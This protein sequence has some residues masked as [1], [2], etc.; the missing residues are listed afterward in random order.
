MKE[1]VVRLTSQ[2]IDERIVDTAA[3]VFAVHGYAKTS[4][5]QIADASGYSK[6]GL[7]HRFTSKQGIYDAVVAQTRSAAETTVA[8]AETLSPHAVLELVAQRLLA[9]PG[10]AAML[11]E[12]LRPAADD[13]ARAGL[14][15]ATHRLVDLLEAG[16]D[17]EQRLRGYLALKLV[18]DAAVLQRSDVD[19][20]L[21]VAATRLQPLVVELAAGV[22]GLHEQE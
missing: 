9:Q 5:Q 3:F 15:A 10:I 11:L 19:D 12:S 21:K 6:T 2:E 18:V 17:P 1:D 16:A 20:H 22:L 4:V 8:A 14:I 13:P 7:L